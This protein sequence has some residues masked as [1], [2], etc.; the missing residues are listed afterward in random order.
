MIRSYLVGS[1]VF[2]AV[3]LSLAS[4]LGACGSGNVPLGTQ[5]SA[6]NG[7]KCQAAGGTCLSVGNDPCSVRAPSSADDCNTQLLPSGP[8]CCL[9]SDAGA[10]ACAPIPCP[11]GAPWNQAACAC[12]P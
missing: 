1:V 6:E 8:F 7:G 3:L 11:S 10:G 4:T 2:T 5:S 12:V 9:V